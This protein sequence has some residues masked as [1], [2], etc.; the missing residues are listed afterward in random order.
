MCVINTTRLHPETPTFHA[1]HVDIH[2][3]SVLMGYIGTLCS[4]QQPTADL[5]EKRKPFDATIYRYTLLLPVMP[6]GESIAFF[7]HVITRRKSYAL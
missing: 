6:K 3:G 4:L 7:Q 2:A 5:H 1:R